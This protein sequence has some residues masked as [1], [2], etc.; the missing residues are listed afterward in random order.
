[1]HQ[2]AELIECASL[3]ASL[4]GRLSGLRREPGVTVTVA[5]DRA[6]VRWDP[7]SSSVLDQVRPVAGAELYSRRG[8]LWYRLGH[9]LPAFGLPVDD[10]AGMPIHRA[11]LPLPVRPEAPGTGPAEPVRLALIRDDTVRP[12]TAI[13]SGLEELGRWAE[14]APS[15]RLSALRAARSGDSI[16]ILGHPLPP[17]VG[18]FRFWGSRVLIPLGM[19]PDPDLPESALRVAM[20]AGEGLLVLNADGAEVVPLGA[21]RPLSRAGI[22]LA[23]EGETR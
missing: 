4:I 15:A 8:G 21:F 17:L 20:G 12:A 7:A 14:M 13:E 1:M 5:G 22:R 16:L 23:L 6:W 19:R 10:G 3:P 18:G 9:R 11:I 2:D